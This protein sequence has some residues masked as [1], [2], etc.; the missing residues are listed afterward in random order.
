[1]PCPHCLLH[2]VQTEVW[3]RRSLVRCMGIGGLSMSLGEVSPLLGGGCPC[4]VLLAWQIWSIG[5]TVP[6][7]DAGVL[8]TVPEA[9]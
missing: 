3:E 7:R 2:E 5:S 8:T 1:M 4:F 6:G 9:S